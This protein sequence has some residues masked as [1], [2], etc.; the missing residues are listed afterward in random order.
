MSGKPSSI[1]DV[2]LHSGTSIATVSNVLNERGNVSEEL[3]ARVLKA[4]QEL[5]Y[6]AS[7]IARSMRNRKTNTI[8]VVVSDI[9]CIFF[10]PVR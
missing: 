1:K 8:C 7:P 6:A 3:Q 2:A 9:N 5:G 10:A 4:A